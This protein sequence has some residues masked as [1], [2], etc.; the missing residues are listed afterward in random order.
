MVRYYI[1]GR[2]QLDNSQLSL[3][4]RNTDAGPLPRS[5]PALGNQTH[6]HVKLQFFYYQYVR[7][8]P[9]GYD[10]ELV[11]DPMVNQIQND[12]MIDYCNQEHFWHSYT[13]YLSLFPVIFPGRIEMTG[14]QHYEF[15]S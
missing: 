8:H 2:H 15:Y 12:S 1:Q 3:L 13:C 14:G 6:Q 11:Y 10:Q 9:S 5:S 4:C 7:L